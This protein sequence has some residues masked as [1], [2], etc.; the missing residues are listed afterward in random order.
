MVEG[1][2]KIKKIW[3]NLDEFKIKELEAKIKSRDKD[4]RKERKP[5][6]KI[7][8]KGIK[9]LK[10]MKIAEILLLLLFLLL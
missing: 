1:R 10:M 3:N 2:I 8:I 9:E 4:I 5:S 7:K 6:K